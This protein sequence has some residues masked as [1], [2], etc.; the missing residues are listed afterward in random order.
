[1]EVRKKER[2]KVVVGREVC[3]SEVLRRGV[4]QRR[5]KG[6]GEEIKG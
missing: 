2:K 6:E 4:E 3:G 1:M 5:G